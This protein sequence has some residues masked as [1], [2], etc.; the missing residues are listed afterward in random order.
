[1]HSNPVH[2]IKI[3]QICQ[4]KNSAPEKSLLAQLVYRACLERTNSRKD[5]MRG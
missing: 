2:Y 1:M 5:R 3:E 4:S